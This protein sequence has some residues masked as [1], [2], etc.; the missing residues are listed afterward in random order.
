MEHYFYRLQMKAGS[1]G[2]TIAEKVLNQNRITADPE[3]AGPQFESLK[4]GEIVFVHK[5]GMPIAIVE[6]IEKVPEEDLL[7]ESFGIDYKVIVLGWY[8]NLDSK[9]QQE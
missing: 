8:K 3:Y 1:D 5:G 9:L 4:K 2:V 6:I 7:E